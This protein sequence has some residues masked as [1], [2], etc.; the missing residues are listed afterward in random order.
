MP[1]G[2]SWGGACL[3]LRGPASW[4]ETTQ[5]RLGQKPSPGGLPP[6]TPLRMEEQGDLR[7]GGDGT[8]GSAGLQPR[9]PVART[10]APCVP[11]P[12]TRWAAYGGMQA[13]CG[14][15]GTAWALP[16]RERAPGTRESSGKMPSPGPRGSS[17][18]PRLLP[19]GLVPLTGPRFSAGE[20]LL[21]TPGTTGRGSLHGQ[22]GFELCGTQVAAHTVPS[23]KV[24]PRL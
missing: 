17:G 2:I 10:P 22:G 14:G 5:P 12:W 8:Q 4:P 13:S 11:A 21:R 20:C 23:R 3:R 24:Q 1:G 16:G 19:W 9:R 6:V 18:L 15:Q 7:S